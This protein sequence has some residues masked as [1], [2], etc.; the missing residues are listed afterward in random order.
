MHC[1]S[2]QQMSQQDTEVIV[3][4]L[5]L[6]IVP[7]MLSTYKQQQATS[8]ETTDDPKKSKA[9]KRRERKTRQI[10]R[11]TN[12]PSVQE[13]Q[14]V[15]SSEA[16]YV[17]G[18]FFIPQGMGYCFICDT[19]V[20]ITKVREHTFACCDAINTAC[21][22]EVSKGTAESSK[23]RSTTSRPQADEPPSKKQSTTE[24][25]TKKGKKLRCFLAG[26]NKFSNA[27]S[28]LGL[29]INKES[30]YF[31]TLD[32]LNKY[33]NDTDSSNALTRKCA[34]CE[35]VRDT[36]KMQKCGQCKTKCTGLISVRSVHSSID[37]HIACSS[38]CVVKQIKNT[39][40]NYVIKHATSQM[41]E[42]DLVDAESGGED[43]AISLSDFDTDSEDTNQSSQ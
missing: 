14:Q 19:T 40:S 15:P 13:T 11:S 39:T 37:L 35:N 32:H 7:T 6:K 33:C 34:S 27:K 20:P 4:N 17:N 1:F 31:C 16:R 25:P 9:M 10:E 2:F 23:K 43:T 41:K 24:A 30:K 38:A 22:T 21:V 12:G 42:K 26:C 18:G 8:I 36:L 29:H 5:L 28:V 3:K